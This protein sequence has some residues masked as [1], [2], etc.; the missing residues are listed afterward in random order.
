MLHVFENGGF[1]VVKH[2]VA[3]IYEMT[4]SFKE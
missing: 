3:G 4:M 2:N 1:D